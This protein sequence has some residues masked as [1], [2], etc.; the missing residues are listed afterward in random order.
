MTFLSFLCHILDDHNYISMVLYCRVDDFSLN[1]VGQLYPIKLLPCLGFLS[2]NQNLYSTPSR[3]LLRGTPDPG[4]V[5]KN[6]LEKAV[7]LRTGNIWE[8]P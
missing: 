6:S 4:Q 1:Q 2:I 3:S 7:E 5:E 8:V